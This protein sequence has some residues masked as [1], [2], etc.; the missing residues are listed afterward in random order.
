LTIEP[1]TEAGRFFR[2]LLRAGVLGDAQAPGNLLELDDESPELVVGGLVFDAI[3]GQLVARRFR[4]G[5][6]VRELH[7][8]VAAIRAGLEPDESLPARETE[9]YLRARLGEPYLLAE[10]D[11]DRMGEPLGHLLVQLAQDVP[12]T[13][14]DIDDL[15]VEA[16]RIAE[17]LGTW[18]VLA[19]GPAQVPDRALDWSTIDRPKAGRWGRGE[20]P[21]TRPGRYVRALVQFDN[22]TLDQLAA[23]M[24]G[25]GELST[26]IT[27]MG[28]VC[29]NLLGTVFPSPVDLRRVTATL[30][31]IRAGFKDPRLSRLSLL[32]IDA[33]ARDD[34]GEDAF[35]DGITL[36]VRHATETMVVAAAAQE[37]PFAPR[38]VDAMV[39]TAE[40][41][42]MRQT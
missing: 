3:V 30:A 13:G 31:R 28:L 8:Y 42:V 34:L 16:E 20:A 9:A 12:L 32:E 35:L 7:R 27:M 23:Q 41:Q 18:E 38:E 17:R 14:A 10:V 22:A 39:T 19:G 5:T 15:V 24:R 40:R 37:V 33:V 21:Q 11:P 36:R 1:R 26:A 2:R 4:P 25:T 29:R 6:D